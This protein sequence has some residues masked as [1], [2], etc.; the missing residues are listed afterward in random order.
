[1]LVLAIHGFV[2]LCREVLTGETGNIV[3]IGV[4]V[5]AFVVYTAFQQRTRA[6]PAVAPAKQKKTN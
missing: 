4:V 6:P 2:F 1:M 5:A 3:V